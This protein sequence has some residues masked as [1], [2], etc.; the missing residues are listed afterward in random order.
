V[1]PNPLEVIPI[2]PYYIDLINVICTSL[3][4]EI[5]AYLL[6]ILD[7]LGVGLLIGVNLAKCGTSTA[8]KEAKN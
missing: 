7:A 8:N 5:H 1:D 6:L 2:G 4:L 3:V